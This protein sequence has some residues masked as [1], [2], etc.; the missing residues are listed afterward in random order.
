M[1]QRQVVGT[2]S[3][4]ESNLQDIFHFNKDEL[5]D[6]FNLSE[7]KNNIKNTDEYFGQQYLDDK[8]KNILPWERLNKIREFTPF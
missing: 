5:K 6:N 2:P 3:F 8:D 1:N 4:M 7:L